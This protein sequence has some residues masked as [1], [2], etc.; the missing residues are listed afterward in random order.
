LKVQL[1]PCT[2]RDDEKHDSDNL[3]SGGHHGP[4]RPP[5][6][7]GQFEG[8]EP[9]EFREAKEI[10]RAAW[11]FVPIFVWQHD[12]INYV[13]D[14]HQRDRVLRKMQEQGYEDL[15]EHDRL[16]HDVVMGLLTEKR[17]P[18][19]GSSNGRWHLYKSRLHQRSTTQPGLVRGL[20]PLVG[21]LKRLQKCG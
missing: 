5:A 6:V 10:N 2:L 3:Q 16:R 9:P 17:D 21:S 11:D 15:N 1:Q 12:G 18:T 20:S 4:C 19:I 13:L 7:A 14:G 8:I